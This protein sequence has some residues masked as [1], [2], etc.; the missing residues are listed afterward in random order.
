MFRYDKTGKFIQRYI[1]PKKRRVTEIIIRDG[2]TGIR[3]SA[4]EGCTSLKSIIIPESVTNI[5]YGAFEGCTS[6]E[7]ITIPE[8]V[9]NIEDNAFDRCPNLII[10]NAPTKVMIKYFDMF[11]KHSYTY[12]NLE[13]RARLMNFKY[14]HWD[15]FP[16]EISP[17][18]E[19]GNE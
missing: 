17:S 10:I 5:E 16:K 15:E 4:F 18:E 1:E 6:L 8:S 13:L 3:P 7:R 2:I 11:M 9:T 19:L 14:D 12:N